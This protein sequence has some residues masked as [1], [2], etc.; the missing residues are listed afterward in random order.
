MIRL[1]RL[2]LRLA[3]SSPPTPETFPLLE[4]A[5]LF[6][7]RQPHLPQMFRY[8]HPIPCVPHKHPFPV[9]P[10][11]RLHFHLCIIRP[12]LP[13]RLS[14]TPIICPLEGHFAIAPH[15]SELHLRFERFPYLSCHLILRIHLLNRIH[16]VKHIVSLP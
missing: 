6:F 12:H 7:L 3:R 8:F 16:F 11:P 10:P 14:P 13:R 2:V 15:Y 5:S 9:P 4:E 1:L